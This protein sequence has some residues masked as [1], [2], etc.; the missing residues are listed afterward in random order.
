MSQL[1]DH[2]DSDYVKSCKDLLKTP[3]GK[4]FLKIHLYE[5]LPPAEFEMSKRIGGGIL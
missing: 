2:E 4:L 1:I 5:L 3:Q